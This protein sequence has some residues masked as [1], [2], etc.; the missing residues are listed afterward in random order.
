MSR[1]V[2]PRSLDTFWEDMTTSE[3]SADLGVTSDATQLRLR[4]L[5]VAGCRDQETDSIGDGVL[6]K[7]NVNKDGVQGT[8]EDQR[9]SRD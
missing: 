7:G 2:G 8:A 9:V 1:T 5:D 6:Q 3:T 4:D